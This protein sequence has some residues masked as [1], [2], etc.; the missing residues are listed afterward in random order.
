MEKNEKI[1][2]NNLYDNHNFPV[3]IKL[4]NYNVN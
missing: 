3:D 1:M 2:P 4:Q